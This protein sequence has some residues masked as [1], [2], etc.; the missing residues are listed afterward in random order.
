MSTPDGKLRLFYALLSPEYVEL[1]KKRKKEEEEE[2]KAAK[3]DRFE[4]RAEA[5]KE[6]R[7]KVQRRMQE[8]HGCLM[9][10]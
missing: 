2:K 9:P 8:L 3:A 10:E 6:F 4:E 7:Q 5:V 1:K